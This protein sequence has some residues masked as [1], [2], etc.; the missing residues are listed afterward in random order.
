MGRL[1]LFEF[2]DLSWF[3][4]SLRNYETDFLR[5]LSNK[6]GLF[7]PV[8]PLINKGLKG[9]NTTT[10]IDLG[11]GGGGPLLS[12]YPLLKKKHPDL[13]ILLTDKFPNIQAFEMIQQRIP[14]VEYLEEPVDARNLPKKLTGLRTLFLLLHHFRQNDAK[15]ILQNAID[16]REPI[17]IFEAQERSFLSIIAMLLSPLSVLL[18]TPFIAPFRI[19]R[20]LFTYLIPIVPLVV[21]WDGVVSSLRTYS[22]REMNELV[23]S[24]KNADTFTWEIGRKKSGPGMILYLLG[25]PKSGFEK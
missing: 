13:K 10:I 4:K 9:S 19:G 5:F 24:L 14:S 25:T 7:K 21:L 15:N 3:P 8:I 12:L 16:S 22:I 23:T 2:E 18:T 1:Q 20:I 17:A 6:T 11:S